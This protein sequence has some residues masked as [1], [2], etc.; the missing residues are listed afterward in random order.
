[1]KIFITGATGFLGQYLVREIALKL[2]DVKEIFILSRNSEFSKF[3]DLENVK[4]IKGDITNPQMIENNVD[5]NNIIEN[6]DFIIHAAALY[7]VMASHSECYLQNV[8]G[9]QNTLRLIK[10]CKKLKAFFYVSTIAVG[11]EETYFLEEDHFPERKKFNDYYSETKYHAEKMVRDLKGLSDCKL[12]IRIIRPGII[13]GDS[14]TGRMDKCDGPYYFMSVL[15]KHSLLLKTIAYLPLSFNPKTR[16]PIIPV[17]HCAQAMVALI[18]REDF[19]LE[20][21]TYHLIS[22]ELPTIKEFLEDINQALGLKTQY[23]PVMKNP[24]HNS[25]LKLLGIPKEL[26]PF[27]FSKLSYDKTRTIEDLPELKKSMYSDYK[28]KLFLYLA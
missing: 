27:M 23:I 9:T 15:K 26:I 20:L 21:K 13:I 18:L 12:P 24:V 7:D 1:M 4:L 11:D 3:S 17:D 25:L 8:V 6:V 14:V 2:F 28:E 19:S 10:N 5:Y 22:S 16:L